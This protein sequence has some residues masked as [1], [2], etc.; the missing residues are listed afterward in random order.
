MYYNFVPHEAEHL[1]VYDVGTGLPDGQYQ[2]SIYVIEESGLPFNR[3][4][5]TPK[6]VWINGYLHA[7][8]DV[9]IIFS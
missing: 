9:I 4:A 5:A 3:T 2:V 1:R 8:E 7:N 6:S